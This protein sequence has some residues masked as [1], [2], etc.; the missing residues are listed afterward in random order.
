MDPHDRYGYEEALSARMVKFGQEEVCAM[1]LD[2]DEEDYDDESFRGFRFPQPVPRHHISTLHLD[3]HGV[4]GHSLSGEVLFE[5]PHSRSQAELFTA[6]MLL[7]LISEET[8]CEAGVLLRD[9]SELSMSD[10][11]GG[12]GVLT[13]KQTIRDCRT[14]L[15]RK[16]YRSGNP[17]LR[18]GEVCP[19]LRDVTEP[20]QALKEWRTWVTRGYQEIPHQE[21]C[22]LVYTKREVVSYE[23]G[24]YEPL[25]P[26]GYFPQAP[27]WKL[28]AG[29]RQWGGARSDVWSTCLRL[30]VRKLLDEHAALTLDRPIPRYQMIVDPNQFVHRTRD[31]PVW[32][33]CEFDISADG[34]ASLVGGTRSHAN[35]HLAQHVAGPVL[36]AALPLLAK[37]RRPQLLLDDRRVQV[38]FKA[39]RIIV[40]G[41]AGDNSDAEYVG[42]WHVDGHR[43]N[44]AAV[45]LYYYHVDSSLRGGDMEL[46]G[47]E[48]MDVLG[49]GDCSNNISGL[50]SKS[51]REALRGGSKSDH[52]S[53]VHNCRVPIGDGTLLV[54]SNYQMAHR[55]LRLKNIGSTE[56]SRDF[57]ALFVL[58][59][60]SPALLPA[61][62]IL[63]APHLLRRTLA[64]VQMSESAIQNVLEFLGVSQTDVERKMQRNRLLSEQLKPSGEFACGGNVYATGNGCYTMI[65]WLH[66]MLEHRGGPAFENMNPE[67]FERL[68]ALNLPPEGSDRGL[69]EVLSLSTAKLHRR[70]RQV[71]PEKYPSDGSEESD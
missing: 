44:V 10:P 7:E 58:D 55:V 11:V 31:G 65:G 4:H 16:V 17:S 67:G 18:E 45:V 33:P 61:R 19:D 43:E 27:L 46:S 42:L 22:W 59:P 69:S 36:S 14:L 6:G 29:T 34:T 3:E 13:L 15:C 26:F 39:Q 70:L 50:G 71:S 60:S 63:A 23:A 37:L 47:R 40:P 52:S 12:E 24:N 41:D 66:N 32:V 68:A 20:V 5:I 30:P 49:F 57:V 8:G 48:P 25:T 54:F 38:V 53:A 9:G 64:P 1:D 56:A 2:E 28:P 51:L 35:P 62:S 21:E